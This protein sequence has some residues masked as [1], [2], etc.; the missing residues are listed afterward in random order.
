TTFGAAVGGSQA[1]RSL[2]TDAPGTTTARNVT[3]RGDIT[4]N[5]D[6]TLNGT[7][8]ANEN[9]ANGN[10]KADKT[11]TLACNTTVSTGR[12]NANF[13]GYVDADAAAKHPFPARR[14]SDLT[15]F[16]AAVGG[17][18]ALRSLTTDAPGT[19]MARNVTTRGDIIFNDDV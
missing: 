6:V 10:F 9:H 1:L 15:T 8:N 11:E 16:G 19:T 13:N 3:T 4:F 14:S 18:Q 2:N 5:D 7:Y 12:G 17:S